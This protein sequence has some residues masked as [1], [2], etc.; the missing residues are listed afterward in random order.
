MA[1][2]PMSAWSS[3]IEATTHLHGARDGKDGETWSDTFN[4]FAIPV[5]LYIG[6]IP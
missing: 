1:I 2:M 4:R 6:V 5:I 3:T